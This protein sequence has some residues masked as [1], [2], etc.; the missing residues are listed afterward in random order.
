MRQALSG[1]ITTGSLMLLAGA[2]GVGLG[3]PLLFPSLGPTAFL[4]AENPPPPS[5]RPYNVLA[6]HGVGI[7]AGFAGVLAT[8]AGNAPALF[9]A[10]LLT[11]ER[12]LAGALAITLTYLGTTVLRAQHPPAAATTL[13]IALGGFRPDLSHA[14]TIMTGVVVVTVV[15]EGLRRARQGELW[16]ARSA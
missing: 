12:V 16:L 4:L 3:Q 2:L 13:L 14:A 1:A 10:H 8:G 5:A 7:I 9:A 15:G 11:P 6:G